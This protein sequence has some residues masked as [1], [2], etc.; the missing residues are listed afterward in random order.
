VEGDV[1]YRQCGRILG[2]GY[3]RSAT[4]GEDDRTYQVRILPWDT[5]ADIYGV[6]DGE[7]GTAQFLYREWWRRGAIDL[8]DRPPLTLF[9]RRHGGT[10][11]GSTLALSDQSWGLDGVIQLDRTYAG[12][13]VQAL[14]Q[15]VKR[16]PVS[17][18]FESDAGDYIRHNGSTP[19]IERIHARLT[20]ISIVERGIYVDAYI[21]GRIRTPSN[22]E[23][24]KQISHGLPALAR[25]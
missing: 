9:H 13:T 24:A 7:S 18:A 4:T 14:L 11:C 15:R 12:D 19:G 6:K 3:L 8:R 25:Q 16:V 22:Q 5:P 2:L 23:L 1:H 21:A 10:E 20:E 17:A